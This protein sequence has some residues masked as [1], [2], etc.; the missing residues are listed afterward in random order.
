METQRGWADC[1]KSHG[2][3]AL[4]PPADPP[5]PP[6]SPNRRLQKEELGDKWWDSR[7]SDWVHRA[8]RAP[9][10]VQAL[11]EGTYHQGWNEKKEPHWCP[12]GRASPRLASQG[13]LASRAPEWAGP[14]TQ[15]ATSL[16]LSP[17]LHPGP[18]TCRSLKGYAGICTFGDLPRSWAVSQQR[19]TVM[20][21]AGRRLGRRDAKTY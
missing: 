8:V 10:A 6:D 2:E 18:L 5:T 20:G 12:R 13:Q 17:S 1:P 7:Q 16:Q 14:T 4:L 21:N 3:W 9:S 15:D 11:Q 19:F